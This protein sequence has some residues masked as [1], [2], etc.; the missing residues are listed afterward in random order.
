MEVS[1]IVSLQGRMAEEKELLTWKQDAER[2]RE[3]EGRCA[4]ES[5]SPLAQLL[6]SPTYKCMSL[7]GADIKV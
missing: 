2:P 7:D 1:S 6:Q 3:E 4:L 5:T